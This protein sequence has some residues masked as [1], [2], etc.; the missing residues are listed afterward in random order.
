MALKRITRRRTLSITSL[1]DVI[2]LL[3]LFF[4]LASTF[5]KFSEMDIAAAGPGDEADSAASVVIELAID[6][7]HMRLDGAVLPAHGWTAA[8]QARLTDDTVVALS[9]A[10]EIRTQRMTDVLAELNQIPGLT[11]YLVET[12]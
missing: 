4:M 5:S 7:H 8:L 12:P 9:V 10:P 2:F 6:A 3:L 11:V 1:I